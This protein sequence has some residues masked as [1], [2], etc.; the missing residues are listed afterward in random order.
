MHLFIEGLMETGQDNLAKKLEPTLYEKCKLEIK[1]LFKAFRIVTRN[2][3]SQWSPSN[4]PLM[5][6]GYYNVGVQS[7]FIDELVG[8]AKGH[9]HVTLLNFVTTP[10]TYLFKE[11]CIPQEYCIPRSVI[12]SIFNSGEDHLQKTFANVEYFKMFMPDEEKEQRMWLDIV[13]DDGHA[14]NG[15]LQ[16]ILDILPCNYM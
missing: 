8:V 13:A 2:R 12:K 5:R 14:V 16:V 11:Y 7:L 6:G 10:L 15:Q 9:I 3:M 1:P 4:Q